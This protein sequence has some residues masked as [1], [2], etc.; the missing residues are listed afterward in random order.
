MTRQIPKSPS[1]EGTTLS[2][3]NTCGHPPHCGTGYNMQVKDYSV[4]GGNIREVQVCKHC[5]CPKCSSKTTEKI[6][7]LKPNNIL[8]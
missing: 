7:K 1:I 6:L 3:C 2:G 8:F 4:D 5:T